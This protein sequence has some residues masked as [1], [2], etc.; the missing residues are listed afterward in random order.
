M[1]SNKDI[2]L[3]SAEAEMRRFS[4]LMNK[5][6][7][8]YFSLKDPATKYARAVGECYRMNKMNFDNTLNLLRQYK[9]LIKNGKSD[10][11]EWLE[12]LTDE[13]RQHYDIFGE[14]RD[15][16]DSEE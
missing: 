7:K 16:R 14:L 6:S 10:Y 3:I 13:Q 15:S 9:S 12:G 1:D 4:K 8:E 2:F 5:A 11:D